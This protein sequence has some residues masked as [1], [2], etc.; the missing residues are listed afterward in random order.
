MNKFM[1][2]NKLKTNNICI[3][4]RISDEISRDEDEAGIREMKWIKRS[5]KRDGYPVNPAGVILVLYC[6]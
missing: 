2:S 1:F 3:M 6:C 4:N 5:V